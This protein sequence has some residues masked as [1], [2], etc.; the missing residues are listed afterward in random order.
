MS[1]VWWR[2]PLLETR[3]KLASSKGSA[4]A[5]P[6]SIGRVE[7]ELLRDALARAPHGV[8]SDRPRSPPPRP[9]HSGRRRCPGRSRRPARRARSTRR[10][11][12]PRPSMARSRGVRP[13]GDRSTRR[14]PAHRRRRSRRRDRRSTARSRPSCNPLAPAS[15]AATAYQRSTPRHARRIQTRRT[16]HVDGAARNC[17]FERIGCTRSGFDSSNGTTRSREPNPCC[18]DQ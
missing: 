1:G 5:S 14:S 6:S 7:A 12:A 11:R 10:N 15:R 17:Q 18:P 3:S 4:S 8:G 2:T 9:G 16:R 13:A